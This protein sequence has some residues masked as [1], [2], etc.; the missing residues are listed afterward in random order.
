MSTAAPLIAP[1]QVSATANLAALVTAARDPGLDAVGARA[2]GEHLLDAAEQLGGPP[3]GVGPAEGRDRRM[4]DLVSR[5]LCH[6]A[7]ARR[8]HPHT[9]ARLVH[10]TSAVEGASPRLPG[11]MGLE[12]LVRWPD[13]DPAT[14]A[15][16]LRGPVLCRQ[17]HAPTAAEVSI[18]A[19]LVAHPVARAA[20]W[21]QA[22]DEQVPTLEAAAHRVAERA[23]Q[24]RAFQRGPRGQSYTTGGLQVI[25]PPVPAEVPGGATDADVLQATHEV[26]VRHILLEHLARTSGAAQ[27]PTWALRLVLLGHPSLW[28]TL[29]A[30]ADLCPLL[31]AG[32]LVLALSPAPD[33]LVTVLPTLPA[34]TVA[35]LTLQD[36]QALL[37]DPSRAVRVAATAVLA[38]APSAAAAP[39]RIQIRPL[40]RDRR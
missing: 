38:R 15:T 34:A 20:H 8:L 28:A 12:V 18:W 23:D 31:D 6:L 29:L 7:D 14:H 26:P 22:L 16:L 17:T 21:A 33:L 10:A 40:L 36:R 30:R 1:T 27:D 5:G 35:R 32:D 25:P 39:G 37:T 11:G 4:L 13:L 3:S 9:A 2:I 19:R 24:V